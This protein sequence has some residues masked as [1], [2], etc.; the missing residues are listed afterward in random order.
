MRS[1]RGWLRPRYGSSTGQTSRPYP[2]RTPPCRPPRWVPPAR[3]KVRRCPTGP[4][5]SCAGLLSGGFLGGNFPRRR[6]LRFGRANVGPI[7]HPVARPR[8]LGYGVALAVD[9]LGQAL[10]LLRGSDGLRRG[11]C[12]GVLGDFLR[13]LGGSLFG[14]RLFG[15]VPAPTSLNVSAS[16][17]V[18][19]CAKGQS[20]IKCHWPSALPLVSESYSRTGLPLDPST[21]ALSVVSLVISHTTA[22]LHSP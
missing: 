22:G 19:P 8:A 9:L 3:R 18:R 7:G 6:L 13:L 5:W 14:R 2:P 1:R 20:G 15:H 16:A 10:G 12:R 17:C 11:L 21:T 4:P